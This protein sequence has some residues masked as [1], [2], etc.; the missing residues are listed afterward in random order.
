[1]RNEKKEEKKE[2]MKNYTVLTG[3]YCTSCS[4]H[5]QEALGSLPATFSMSRDQLVLP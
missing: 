4:S 5:A 1:V 3:K 2:R